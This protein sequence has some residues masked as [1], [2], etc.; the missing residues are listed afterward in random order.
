MSLSRLGSLRISRPISRSLLPSLRMR[1]MS[2]LDMLDMGPEVK[3][4]EDAV[5]RE[6]V[7]ICLLGIGL[8]EAEREGITRGFGC[9]NA[10]RPRSRGAGLRLT[11]DCERLL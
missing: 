6:D 9:S 1:P 4:R 10:A 2:L 5:L 7:D 8:S 11:T 3:P